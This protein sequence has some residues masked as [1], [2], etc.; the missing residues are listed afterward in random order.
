MSG[1]E[2]WYNTLPMP[3]SERRAATLR[4][5][6]EVDQRIREDELRVADPLL[7]E[8]E[9]RIASAQLD[10]RRKAVGRV[11]AMLGESD[12]SESF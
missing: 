8:S 11:E 1:D 4:R 7:S 9:R 10:F 2:D 6:A 12:D 5:L 3:L